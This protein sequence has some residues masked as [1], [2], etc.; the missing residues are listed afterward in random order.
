M[1]HT[2]M[3]SFLRTYLGNVVDTFL[4]RLLHYRKQWFVH[5]FFRHWT[6]ILM[7]FF[8]IVCIVLFQRYKKHTG[9][10]NIGIL[11]DLYSFLQTHTYWSLLYIWAFLIRPILFFPASGLIFLSGALYGIWRGFFYTFLGMNLSAQISYWVGRFFTHKKNTHALDIPESGLTYDHQKS[12]SDAALT[13]MTTRLIFLHFDITNY[14]AG[15]KKVHWL[16]Y[17]LGTAIGI[18]PDIFIFILAGASFSRAVPWQPLNFHHMHPRGHLLIFS[19]ALLILC[20][21]AAKLIRDYQKKRTTRAV[22][23]QDK[24]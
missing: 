1:W 3:F 12:W 21:W 5:L 13:M 23:S 22:S 14:V 7:L 8:W 15:A 9:T 10:N 4:W 16:W 2:T 19:L 6:K 24:Q 17:T 20:L 11:E 18:I